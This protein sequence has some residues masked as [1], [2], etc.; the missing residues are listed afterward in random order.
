MAA[1]FLRPAAIPHSRPAARPLCALRTV[2]IRM[3]LHLYAEIDDGSAEAAQRAFR[4]LEL[5]AQAPLLRAAAGDAALL[6]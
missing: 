3:Q 6:T 1:L 5:D 4:W 2:C